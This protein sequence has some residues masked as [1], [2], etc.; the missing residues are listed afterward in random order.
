VKAQRHAAIVR[1]VRRERVHSQEQL[2]T[3]L[4]AEGMRVTQATLSR[5]IHDLRL[6]KLADPAGGAYYSVPPDREVPNPSFVQMLRTLLLS[7]EGVGPLLVARTPEGSAE[8][9][10]GAFDRAEMDGVIGTIAGDDTILVITKSAAARKSL[11][12]Q[13][14]ELT[15][16]HETTP[17]PG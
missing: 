13:L 11:T 9:L 8:A 14:Q 5:D 4:A 12:R 6:A 17:P 10:G 15:G 3:M 1:L 7:M 2:R 16:G